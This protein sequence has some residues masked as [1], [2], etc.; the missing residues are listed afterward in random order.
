MTLPGQTDAPGIVIGSHLDS[1]PMGGNFDGAAGVLMG[2]SVVSGLV[3]AG[4]VPPRPITVMAIRAEERKALGFRPHI[5]AA[6][7][8]SGGCYLM[9]SMRWCA[10]VMA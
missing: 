1:V 8:H 3:G 7:P 2:L 6:G 5:S 9:S 10:Q 4:Q